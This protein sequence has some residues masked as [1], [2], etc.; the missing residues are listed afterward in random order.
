MDAFS[1]PL[2]PLLHLPDQLTFIN[3]PALDSPGR[4]SPSSSQPLADFDY[5][6]WLNPTPG[7]TFDHTASGSG[8]PGHDLRGSNGLSAAPTLRSGVGA[9]T[10]TRTEAVAPGFDSTIS[11]SSSIRDLL[12]S[13]TAQYSTAELMNDLFIPGLGDPHYP[14]HSPTGPSLVPHTQHLQ[15]PHTT[16]LADLRQIAVAATGIQNGSSL[17]HAVQ[18]SSSTGVV[19][20]HKTHSTD[21][22]ESSSKPRKSSNTNGNDLSSSMK[23]GKAPKTPQQADESVPEAALHLLRLALPTGSGGSVA[24]STTLGEEDMS[25]DEDAEGESD[26]TSVHWEDDASLVKVPKAKKLNHRQQ[27]QVEGDTRVWEHADGQPPLRLQGSGGGSRAGSGGR[28][29]VASSIASGRVRQ[30]RPARTQREQSASTRAGSEDGRLAYASGSGERRTSGRIRKPV[31]PS[32]PTDYDSDDGNTSGSDDAEDDIMV[33]YSDS[34]ADG[35]SSKKK[36][37]TA[38][39]GKG[40]AVALKPKTAA[41]RSLGGASANPTPAKKARTSSVA[42]STNDGTPSSSSAPRR[43]RRLPIVPTNLSNRTFPPQIEIS[44]LFPRFYRAFPIS[45]A[46]PPDSYVHLE[47]PSGDPDALPVANLHIPLAPNSILSHDYHHN[48]YDPPNLDHFHDHDPAQGGPIASTSSGTGM[49]PLGPIV[50][51]QQQQLQDDGPGVDFL[52]PPPESKWN[53]A[54]DPFNLYTPKFVKGNADLKAGMCPIC[55]EPVA[56]GGEGEEKWLKVRFVA[57]AARVICRRLSYPSQLK[58]SSYVYHMSYAH[59]LSNLTG[60]SSHSPSFALS[61]PC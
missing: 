8:V 42:G 32:G 10:K 50:G 53:K 16:P 30:H 14:H 7:P 34:D 21:S 15:R 9:A 20:S 26:A 47:A 37:K 3:P 25:C 51:D 35:G 43:P 58:N 18:A 48:L 45:S 59:G 19:P 27:Q 61:L 1:L 38:A 44:P 46:F 52:Q 28:A 55:V 40:K 31:L 22:I 12:G 23:H 56:R 33:D 4:A 54:T 60:T 2:D 49:P 39:K 6:S 36:K 5:S 13:T 24:T 17:V 11:A 57:A 41:K 29:S